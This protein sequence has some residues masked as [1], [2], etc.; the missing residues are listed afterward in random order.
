M[1]NYENNV[2]INMNEPRTICDN[3]DLIKYCRGSCIR[4]H[5]ANVGISKQQVS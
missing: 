4:L 1:R 3:I 5:V 2:Q